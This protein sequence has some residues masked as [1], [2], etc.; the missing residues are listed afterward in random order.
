MGYTQLHLSYHYSKTEF[1]YCRNFTFV[2]TVAG[3][4][5]LEGKEYCPGTRISLPRV[6]TV[7][8]LLVIPHWRFPISFWEQYGYK[9]QVNLVGFHQENS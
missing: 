5:R 1:S 2:V 4:E 9:V 6:E 7:A 8:N 3:G